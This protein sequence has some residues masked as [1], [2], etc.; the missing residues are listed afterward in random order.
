MQSSLPNSHISSADMLPGIVAPVP[1]SP[2]VP[3]NHRELDMNFDQMIAE[4]LI[5]SE[6]K[7]VDI[8]RRV[9]TMTLNTDASKKKISALIT[10]LT[11]GVTETQT[12]LSN[13]R[14]GDG[15]EPDVDDLLENLNARFSDSQHLTGSGNELDA[16][17]EN[18]AEN[19]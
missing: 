10:E 1:R 15:D 5:R 17:F 12:I 3:P 4:A 11:K 19:H 7:M 14:C 8:S 16:L 9:A 18:L 13:R 2:S 6:H